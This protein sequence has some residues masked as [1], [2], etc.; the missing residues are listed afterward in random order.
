LVADVGRHLDRNG[1]WRYRLSSIYQE[2]EITTVL[3][4][5][6]QDKHIA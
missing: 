5:L 4:E 3:K 2:P 6:R 1:P